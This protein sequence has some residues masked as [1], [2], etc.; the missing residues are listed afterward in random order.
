M[1]K[2]LYGVSLLALLSLASCGESFEDIKEAINNE[3]LTP[4]TVKLLGSWQLEKAVLPNGI[5][6]TNSCFMQEVIDFKIDGTY[7]DRRNQIN[8]ETNECEMVAEFV[9]GYDN[10]GSIFETS[11]NELVI[12]TYRVVNKNELTLNFS[13]PFEAT[14]T[15][16]RVY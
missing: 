2:L 16:L 1:K 14:I 9:R 13:I 8:P 4:N 15:Y 5:D 10:E 12:A 3:T 11:D 7:I 6:V